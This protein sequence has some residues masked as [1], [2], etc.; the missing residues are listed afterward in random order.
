MKVLS[1]IWF[2]NFRKNNLDIFNY[3]T[4]CKRS[5]GKVMFLHLSVILFTGG[6]AS[7]QHASLFTWPGGLPSGE[8]LFTWP[9]GLPRG[10]GVC[11]LRS[12]A[13]RQTPS[14][15][16]VNRWAVCILL[17][18]ILV[19]WFSSQLEFKLVYG[20]GARQMLTTLYHYWLN[21]NKKNLTYVFLLF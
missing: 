18:C 12:S 20:P 14:Q 16:M 11:L 17:E 2:S 19:K 7:S 9:G 1:R 21:T 8:S 5:C 4:V 13:S 6:S 10:G 3:F 15:D